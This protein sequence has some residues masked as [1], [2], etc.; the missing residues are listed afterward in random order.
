MAVL[1]DAP[2][3]VIGTSSFAIII[4]ICVTKATRNI[5]LT[6]SVETGKGRRNSEELQGSGEDAD[7][8]H[9]KVL[10]Y[11]QLANNGDIYKLEMLRRLDKKV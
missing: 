4:A 8:L 7:G 6:G 3:P 1:V 5:N 2:S 11:T 10:E 9:G